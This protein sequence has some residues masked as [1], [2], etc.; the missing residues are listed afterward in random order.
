MT[1]FGY[2]VLV[3]V[4]LLSGTYT[5]LL[6]IIGRAPSWW[7][8][9]ATALVELALVVQ[10]LWSSV[11]VSQGASATGDTLEFFG[12]VITA[13]LIPPASVLWAIFE[14]T[15]WSTLV[16]GVAGLTIAVMAVRMWQIWSGNVLHF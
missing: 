8:V 3:S 2:Q 13:L 15:R 12:Y 6:G 4:S 10:L 5:L 7:S 11:L 16:M 9:S 1:E 14:R